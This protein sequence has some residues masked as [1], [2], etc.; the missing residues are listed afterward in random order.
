M[1]KKKKIDWR[2]HL[3]TFTGLAVAVAD[4]WVHIDWANFD[5][6]REWP[7]LLL[8]AVIAAGGYLSRFSFMEKKDPGSI[9]PPNLN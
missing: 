3:A 5:I 8:D 9:P 1:T 4:A 2:H 7:K 6:S